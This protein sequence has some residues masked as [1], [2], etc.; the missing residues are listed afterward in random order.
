ML[1]WERLLRAR[2]STGHNSPEPRHRAL[3][4]NASAWDSPRPNG[5]VA[6]AGVSRF[7]ADPSAPP[8]QTRVGLE[9]FDH[10][11]EIVDTDD[12]FELETGAILGGPDAIG[13]D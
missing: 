4:G 9:L 1:E 13:L 3:A 2:E 6:A 5:G 7:G 8:A 11:H 12:P 10:R